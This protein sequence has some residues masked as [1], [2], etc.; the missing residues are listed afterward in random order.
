[1]EMGRKLLKTGKG[2]EC[3]S[4]GGAKQTAPFPEKREG[5]QSAKEEPA[6]LT[7]QW[8]TGPR[9]NISIPPPPPNPTLT[10]QF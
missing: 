7:E 3:T 6:D 2:I 9:W 5:P 10:S 8:R 4:L 1:M